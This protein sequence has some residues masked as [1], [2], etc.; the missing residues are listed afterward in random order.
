MKRTNNNGELNINNIGQTVVLKGWVSKKRDLGGLV[1]I[2]LRDIHGITQLAFNPDSPLYAKT[3]EIKNEYV[4]EVTGKVIERASKN[5]NIPTGDIEVE[6]SEMNILN[7]AVTTPLIIADET[8]ALEEVRLKYRYLDLRRPLMQNTF[9]VR[10]QA[11]TAVREFLNNETFIEFETPILTKSTPEGARDYLV[12]SRINL[13]TSAT[14]FDVGCFSDTC[15]LF[16]S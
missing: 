8:D 1:F 16:S 9:L 14:G 7:D 5:K 15:G 6:V 12:P 10:H 3:L 4:L 13:A 11:T 2:D